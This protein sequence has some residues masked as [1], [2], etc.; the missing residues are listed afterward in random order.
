MKKPKATCRGCHDR[1]VGC[2]ADCEKYQEYHEALM[3]YNAMIREAKDNAHS[4]DIIERQARA[5]YRKIAEGKR[6]R[7]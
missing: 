7:P 1:T 4:V 6:F 3:K 2:H 5:R